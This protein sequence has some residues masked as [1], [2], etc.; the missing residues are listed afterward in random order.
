MDAYRVV[1]IRRP[2]SWRPE[3]PDDAPPEAA[4]WLPGSEVLFESGDLFRAVQRAVDHNELVMS[5]G[6]ERWAV[7]VDVA[8]D[9]KGDNTPAMRVCTPIDYAVAAIWWPEGWEPTAPWD[10]PK[11]V[12]PAHGQAGSREPLRPRP[13]YATVSATMLAL[14]R[15][16]MAQ[17]GAAWYVVVAVESQSL[18]RTVAWDPA[19]TQTTTEVRRLHVVRPERGGLGDCCHCPA[20]RLPCCAG[21]DPSDRVQTVATQRIDRTEETQAG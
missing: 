12:L 14:N 2:A 18:G 9:T 21:V 1:V 6:T 13:S 5:Q 11:C 4:R 20:H 19:G 7:V 15:Q 10:V 3:R 8:D 16:C 17:A